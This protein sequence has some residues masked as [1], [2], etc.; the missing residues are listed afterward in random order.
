MSPFALVAVLMSLVALAGWANVKTLRLPHGVAMMLAGLLGALS[1]FAVQT[2]F[3]NLELLKEISGV[4][5]GI[6]FAQTVTGY[7]LAFL[8]FAGAMQVDLGEMRRRWFP[9]GALATLGVAGSIIIVGFGLWLI[10]GALGIALPL[11]WALTFGALISPTDPVAVLATV[12]HVKLSKTLTSILQGEALFNDGVG[13]VAFTALVAVATGGDAN[14]VHDVM[15]VLVEALGGLALGMAAS[16]TVIGLMG[17]LDD[18]AVETS[19]SIALA[20]SVY[21]GAQALH[22]SGAIAV[23]GAGMLFGGQRARKAMEGETDSYLHGFWTLVD[24]ILNALL[25]LLLGV[26]LIAVPFYAHEVGLLLAAIPLVLIARLAVV[27]PWGVYYRFRRAERGATTILGWG[28]LHGALSL[29]LAL[30]LPAG[31]ERTLLLAV[32]YAVVAFSIAVQGLS[33]GPVVKRVAT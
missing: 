21:A 4:V 13:I 10:A 15:E 2:V 6:D 3:P 29:A 11:V 27:I 31:T 5:S 16:W 19:M 33:F 17:T 12:R 20:M 8:L 1:V 30:S 23:V 7:M 26:E 14:P 9:I 28:G 24:E 22:L 32:T 18:F 25:F